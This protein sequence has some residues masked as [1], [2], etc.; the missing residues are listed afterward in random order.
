M[1]KFLNNN[2]KLIIGFIFGVIITGTIVYAAVSASEIN[3]TTSKN[4]SVK[5]VEQALNDLYN[6]SNNNSKISFDLYCA[7]DS[8][9]DWPNSRFES[10]FTSA[11]SIKIS[12]VNDQ[13]SSY[14]S[15]TLDA[16]GANNKAIYTKTG[17]YY[18]TS[19]TSNYTRVQ[20]GEDVNLNNVTYIDIIVNGYNNY[21]TTSYAI[22]HVEIE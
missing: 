17:V 4:S 13:S 3:Y 12:C 15:D 19:K 6:K 22:G 8:N 10:E 9:R 1:K 11:K 5:N 2:F 14:F 18:R 7:S 16:P 21:S 20:Y